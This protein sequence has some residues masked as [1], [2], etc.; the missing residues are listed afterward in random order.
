METGRTILLVQDNDDDAELTRMAFAEA[1][2]ASP[3]VRVST[4][5]AA[6]RQLASYWMD[7][8]RPAPA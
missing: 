8:N 7:L 5:T 6:S 3:I 1:K 4:G 2:I